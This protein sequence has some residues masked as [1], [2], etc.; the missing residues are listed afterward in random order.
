M[1]AAWRSIART[2][3][4]V[5]FVGVTLI[6]FNLLWFFCSLPLFTLPPA[7]GALYVVVREL[8]DRREVSGRDFLRAMRAHFLD[9]WRWGIVNLVAGF[10]FVV[11]FWFYSQLPSPFGLLL[12]ALLIGFL[13]TWLLV[14]MYTYPI[15]LRQV[16]PRVRL[17]IRN[18][19]ALCLRHP[20]FTLI[21]ALITGIFVFMSLVVP[22]FWMLF[23][24]A[25]V[26]YFYNQAVTTLLK[27]ERGTDPFAAE[28]FEL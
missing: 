15:L 4:D 6:Y 20:V 5:R 3:I 8:G 17:A 21:H 7:T 24:T 23:T 22:Y 28:E 18:A 10:L 27:I 2:V 26:F 14:Q 25:L 9:G 16:Q 12:T 19:F 1:F 11:N 13:V